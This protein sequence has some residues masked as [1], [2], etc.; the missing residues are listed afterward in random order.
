M[1]PIIPPSPPDAHL[2][3]YLKYK[4][5]AKI[6]KQTLEKVFLELGSFFRYLEKRKLASVKAVTPELIRQY[7]SYN[8]RTSYWLTKRPRTVHTIFGKRNCLGN[9]FEFLVQM[10][11]LEANPV[12]KI[13]AP[14]LPKKLPRYLSLAQAK[15]LLRFLNAPKHGGPNFDLRNRVYV[16][17]VLFYGLKTHEICRI[18]LKDINF[19][20]KTITIRQTIHHDA[21]KLPLLE[22]I[23]LWLRAYLRVRPRRVS[24]ILL[25]QVKKKGVF[26]LYNARGVWFVYSAELGFEVN[27]T[28][29]RNTF[30]YYMFNNQV[31]FRVIQAIVGCHSIKSIQRKSVLANPKRLEAVQK[32]VVV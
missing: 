22:P 3:E 31:P 25:Q 1:N 10:K 7:L 13:K 26:S 28:I 6:T 17:L 23:S 18:K 24:K 29:L 9:Y 30:L 20:R 14:I 5:L 21:R 4:K 27:S 19:N 2:P 8:L 12:K 11:H 16:G 32:L 15:K